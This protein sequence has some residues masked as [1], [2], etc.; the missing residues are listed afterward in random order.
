LLRHIRHCA[1]HCDSN[2]VRFRIKALGST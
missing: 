2:K 1:F